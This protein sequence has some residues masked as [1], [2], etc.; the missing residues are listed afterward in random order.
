MKNT[1]RL[2]SSWLKGNEGMKKK[3]MKIKKDNKENNKRMNIIKEIEKTMVIE[4]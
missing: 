3:W 1:E 4:K 2:I